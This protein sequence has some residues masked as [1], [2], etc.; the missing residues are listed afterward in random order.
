MSIL[1]TTTYTGT[2]NAR[3]NP[4]CSLVIPGIDNGKFLSS[5][6]SP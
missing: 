6:L 3:L 2:P 4:R 1:V 5:V